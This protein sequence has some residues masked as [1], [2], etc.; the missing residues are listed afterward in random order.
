MSERALWRVM[1][2]VAVIGLGVATFLTILH[3]TRTVV[4]CAAH[5]N[6]CEVVQT[7]IYSHVLG[8]PVALLG[9]LG[10]VAILVTLLVPPSELSR[11]ATLGVTLFGVAFSGYLTYREIFTLKAICE[12]CVSSAVMMALLFICA[13]IRY[14][15]GSSPGALAS[16][17]AS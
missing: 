11:V 16:P 7:S 13:V 5:G 2:V 17:G 12:W 9:L 3:Y 15:R 1:V 6:P 10:Y 4:P 14:W 8:I